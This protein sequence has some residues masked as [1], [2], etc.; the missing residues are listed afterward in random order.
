MP[1]KIADIIYG[2]APCR[3]NQDETEWGNW[4]LAVAA[5]RRCIAMNKL[6]RPQQGIADADSNACGNDGNFTVGEL[7]LPQNKEW[8]I[9]D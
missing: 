2:Q 3:P 6:W 8:V 9:T 5:N 7:W 4:E 1:K